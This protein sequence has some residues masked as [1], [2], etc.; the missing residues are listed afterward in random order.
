MIN[1][2]FL[3][4]LN[5]LYVEDCIPTQ[6]SIKPFLDKFFNNVF[7]CLN[8]EDA[9]QK[10]KKEN[11]NGI[12]IDI[13][14]TDINMPKMNGMEL[15]LKLKELDR[16]IKVIVTSS[17]IDQDTF[18]DAIKL[19]VDYYATKP[20]DVGLLI[21]EIQNIFLNKQNLLSSQSA[22]L[23]VMNKITLISKMNTEGKITF[24]ND[25]Y[26]SILK[27]SL[28]EILGKEY[29]CIFVDSISSYYA[30]GRDL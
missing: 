18:L 23:D 25:C 7:F 20:L 5:I 26:T 2:K 6:K 29:T 16:N 4:S 13:L 14:I 30:C 3:E 11:L 28:D 8:G 19:K 24:I 12:K 15:I 10:Y 21:N 9:L 27:Y 17:N 22:Y 1:D